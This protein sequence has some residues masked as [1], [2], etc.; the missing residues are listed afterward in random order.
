M[1]SISKNLSFK[2]YAGV[3][4]AVTT[5]VSQRLVSALWKA[6]TGDTPPNPNDPDV[7]ATEAAIW[8][9]ASGIG[10]GATQLV[11]NRFLGRRYEAFFGEHPDMQGKSKVKL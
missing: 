3:I 2:V 7:P 9:L 11:M 6:S 8:A 1:A 10:L 4:G 5:M